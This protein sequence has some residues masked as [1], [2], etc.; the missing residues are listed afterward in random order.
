MTGGVAVILGRTGRNFGAGMSGGIAYVLDVDG[1][2]ASR[3]NREM[4][5]LEPLDSE[6]DVRLYGLVER[7]F[8]ETNSAVAERLL[9][10][11]SASLDRFVKVM[12]QD[13]RRVLEAQQ[14]AAEQGIDPVDAMMEAA[15]G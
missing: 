12:P 2:F 6:D 3:V 5:D 13:Y 14:R 4:V 1:R 9:A 7:H 15:H 10:D 8:S 11:W